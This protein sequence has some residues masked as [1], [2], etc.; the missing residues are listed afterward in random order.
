MNNETELLNQLPDDCQK[1]IGS[2]LPSSNLFKTAIISKA[3]WTLFNDGER[4]GLAERKTISKL[5]GHVVNGE[6]DEVVSM[7]NKDITL[8][9]KRGQ[10]TD[11]SERQFRG[12]N[13]I[14][15]FEYALWALDKH[16]WTAML[17]CLPKEEKKAEQI[18]ERL[19]SQYDG[20][21]T[22]GVSYQLNNRA[23]KEKHFDFENIIIKALQNV[24][25]F[26]KTDQDFLDA[27]EADINLQMD[28][29][30]L[31]WIEEAG[32]AQKLLPMHVVYEYCSKQKFNQG[33]DFIS[34]PESNQELFNLITDE[35]EDWYGYDSKLWV[36]FAVYKEMGALGVDGV[37]VELH[38]LRQDLAAIT[39]LY[40]I[41]ANNFIHLKSQLEQLNTVDNQLSI[42]F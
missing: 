10:I 18:Y 25:N 36:E 5:L 4:A 16:M 39:E 20:V 13:E 42:G 24:V 11:R 6:H 12:D 17:D 37:G 34:K 41:R 1:E 35:C 7:L 30:N 33:L 29:V 9:Y 27:S 3:H 22:N 26:R 19:R 14:S 38:F 21:N 8:M 2:W 31:Q 28:A 23:I 40:K 15:A 32:S